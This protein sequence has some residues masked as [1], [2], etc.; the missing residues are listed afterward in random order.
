MIQFEVRHPSGK[1]EAIAVEG[2]RALVGSG[3]HCDVRLPM[4][5]AAYEHV[6][7][8][9]LGGTLRAEAR[10]DDPKATINDMPLTLATLSPGAVLGVGRVR[11]FVSFTAD[12]GEGQAVSTTKRKDSSPLV[13]V[14]VAAA[15]GV[16]GYLLLMEGDASIPRAPAEAPALF[17]SAP[18]AC[19][20]T[21]QSQA[22]AFAEEQRDL[23]DGKRERLPFAIADGVGAVRFY[24]TAAACFRQGGAEITA[25]DADEAAKSLK[26]DLTDELRARALRLSHMLEVQD[27]PLALRDVTVLRAL[28]TGK[29]GKYVEWLATVSKQLEAKGVR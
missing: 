7:I 4:E 19:P 27:Y 20:P 21:D 6:V 2:E 1:R 26:R 12:F 8:E 16:G 11:L 5:D 10:A 18:V 29:Q 15:F 17:A 22:L 14:A 13:A 24:E 25:L 3:S 23:A 28:T 9:A